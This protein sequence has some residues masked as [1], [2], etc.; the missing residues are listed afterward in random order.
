MWKIMRN[1]LTSIYY[2]M[3][4]LTLILLC[5][6]HEKTKFHTA[7]SISELFY[8]PEGICLDMFVIATFCVVTVVCLWRDYKIL[9]QIF[10]F[11]WDE[12]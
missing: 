7:R 3:P 6:V 4:R 12:D 8:W 2:W 10:T 11:N 5:E 1:Y 9:S